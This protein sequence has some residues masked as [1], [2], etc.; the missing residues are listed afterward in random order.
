MGFVERRFFARASEP[1]F[2]C[3]SWKY[4]RI[5]GGDELNKMIVLYQELQGKEA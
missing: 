2:F 1:P 3:Y 5:K 4:V